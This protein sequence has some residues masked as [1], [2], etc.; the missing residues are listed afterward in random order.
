MLAVQATSQDSVPSVS[1]IMICGPGWPPPKSHHRTSLL[2]SHS[3]DTF[4]HRAAKIHTGKAHKICT[5]DGSWYRHPMTNRYWSNY[6]TCVDTVDLAVSSFLLL[7]LPLCPIT[8]NI[9]NTLP[10]TTTALLVVVVVVVVCV[11][12]HLLSISC[13]CFCGSSYFM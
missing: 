10:T 8:N 11:Y 12:L 13:S 2:R 9:S 7:F 6:T 3:I 1:S 5:P 4:F